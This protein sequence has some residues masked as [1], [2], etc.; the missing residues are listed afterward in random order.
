M[1][2]VAPPAFHSRLRPLSIVE[3]E[4]IVRPQLQRREAMEEAERQARIDAQ[5]RNSFRVPATTTPD[6]D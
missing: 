6:K 1:K 2:P 5:R 4:R 3:L